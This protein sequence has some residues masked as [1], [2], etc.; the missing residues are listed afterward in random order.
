MSQPDLMLPEMACSLAR[1]AETHLRRARAA[2]APCF[3]SPVTGCWPSEGGVS[4]EALKLLA[5]KGGVIGANAY[6]M[7][8]PKEERTTLKDYLDSIEV[9]IEKVGIDH[10][11]I[12]TDFTQDQPRAFFELLFSQQGTKKPE[13]LPVPW[14]LPH[15][16]TLETPDKFANIARGLAERGSKEAEI[17]KVVGGNWLTLFQQVW[18]N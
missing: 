18:K 4:E 3:A 2:A 16:A 15:P 9:L 1:D 10:V 14:P 7:F 8:L 5:E 6:P 17:K 13:K 12:G 11:A